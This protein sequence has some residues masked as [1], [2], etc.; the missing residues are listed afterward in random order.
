MAEVSGLRSRNHFEPNC[1]SRVV[2]EGK[3]LLILSNN[4]TTVS[5]LGGR[6]GVL[7]CSF[8]SVVFVSGKLSLFR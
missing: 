4:V 2:D 1:K 7:K 8:V 3:P 6:G 5:Q